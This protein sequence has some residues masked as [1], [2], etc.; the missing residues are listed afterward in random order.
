MATDTTQTTPPTTEQPVH[1][2]NIKSDITTKL[3]KDD[4]SD[5]IPNQ[6]TDKQT[7]INVYTTTQIN[8]NTNCTSNPILSSQPRF[9]TSDIVKKFPHI[10]PRYCHKIKISLP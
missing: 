10:K 4:I 6:T 2:S 9:S 1:V 7:D 3:S 5:T 8:T